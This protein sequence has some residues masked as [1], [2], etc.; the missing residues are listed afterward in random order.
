MN[1]RCPRCGTPHDRTKLERFL[2]REKGFTATGA[3]Q[4]A[5]SFIKTMQFVHDET[6]LAVARKHFPEIYEV[7][8]R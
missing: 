5:D 1:I 3:R 2:Q 6:C 4:A 8:P 7:L